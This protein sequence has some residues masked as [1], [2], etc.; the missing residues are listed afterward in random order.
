VLNRRAFDVALG[1]ANADTVVRG[2]R[3]VNVYTGEILE[4]DAAIADDV[5]AIVG[6]ATSVID[7]GTE[8]VDVDGSYLVPGLIDTH[9]H[10]EVGKMSVTSYAAAVLPHGTTSVYSALDHIACVLGLRGVRLTLDEA[11]P[12]PFRLYNP[13]PCKVPHTIPASTVGGRVGLS[14]QLEA[15]DW[16]E[17]RGIAEISM[18]F[19][20]RDDEE[21]LSAIEATARRHL[22]AHGDAPMLRARDV[23]AFMCAGLRD[24][25]EMLDA[26]EMAEKLRAGFYCLI[27]ECPSGPNLEACIKVI[28]E[29]GLTSR[30][31]S[32]CTDDADART[33]VEHGHM[34][35][36]VRKAIR[37]GVD[38]IEAIQMGTLHAAEALRLDQ[39]IGAIGPGLYADFL[40]V[41]DLRAFEVQATWVAGQEVARD[42]RMTVQLEPP[43]RAGELMTTFSLAPVTADDIVVRRDVPDGPVRVLAMTTE[44][45]TLRHRRDVTL[46]AEDGVILPDPSL[47][48]CY[49]SVFE[50]YRNSGSHAT[51]FMAGSGLREGALVT[52]NCPDD[53]NVLCLGA[54]AQSMA[55]AINR[56]SE[57]GGGQVVA[58]GDEILAEIALPIAGI[59][60]DA[61]PHEVVKA[62]GE[63][64]DAA[65]SL[66]ATPDNPFAWFLFTQLTTLPHYSLIDRGLVDYA[67][68]S[69]IDPVLGA[70]V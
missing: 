15:L 10:V 23:N 35:H 27:R 6:D 46:N 4:A 12:L 31:V 59:M 37:L 70:A 55:T 64:R 24:D 25:H 47:D 36:I 69:L 61:S 14:E 5:F 66:G 43:P 1:R 16:D 19:L 53:Q 58:C 67:S 48:V 2:G 28:T 9:V 11:A 17:A 50:R 20:R 38:P 45:G 40:V 3:V 7:A 29:Q 21:I 33:L 41:R 18:D 52:S 49:I 54:D 42:G 63:L 26:D 65:K 56:V 39:E 32:F 34:D 13:L 68:L 22:L 44:D 57:L 30:R 51:A 62:D 8:V 60:T